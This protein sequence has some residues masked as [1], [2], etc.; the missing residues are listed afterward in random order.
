MATAYEKKGDY[1]KAIEHHNEI[2]KKDS[3]TAETYK[4]RGNVYLNAQMPEKALP[5][6]G[7]AMS[8]PK[9]KDKKL[10]RGS[11]A[12]A[13]LNVEKYQ[14]AL[15]NYNIVIDKEKVKNNPE[16]YYNRNVAKTK[17]GD[18]QGAIVDIKECV[19]L[20]P[21]HVKG[22]RSTGFVGSKVMFFLNE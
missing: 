1:T 3:A 10:A 7:K 9:L 17:F 2:I 22:A 20:K 15:D 12:T 4:N 8:M 5:D 14:Q 6:L 19:K 21:S 18:N 11:L 16:Y 13:Q